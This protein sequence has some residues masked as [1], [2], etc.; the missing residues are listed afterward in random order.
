M[1]AECKLFNPNK[2]GETPLDLATANNHPKIVKMISEAMQ[3]TSQEQFL[4]NAQSKYSSSRRNMSK[5]M[6]ARG[7]T[8]KN[9]IGVS[10]EDLRHNHSKGN[11][12]HDHSQG[13][14]DRVDSHGSLHSNGSRRRYRQSVIQH[15]FF[16]LL[17]RCS[18]L[19][20]ANPFLILH[21]HPISNSMQLPFT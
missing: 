8:S 7:C 12:N 20:G 1:E 10:K 16:V 14:I 21:K 18:L 4:S 13:Y 2:K 19:V 11:M 5:N 3:K 6:S 9:S 15:Y 17:L